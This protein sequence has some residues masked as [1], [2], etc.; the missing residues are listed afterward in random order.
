MPC[1]VL[2]ASGYGGDRGLGESDGASVAGAA[3]VFGFSG[4]AAVLRTLAVRAVGGI[5]SGWF[6]YYED[7]DLSWR[8]RLAGWQIVY[9]PA[10]VV[11]HRHAASSRTSR[12]E[13]F[14]FFNERNRLLTLVRNAPS[15]VTA[16]QLARFVVNDPVTGGE[17]G[18]Q[19]HGPTGSGVPS[20]PAPSGSRERRGDPA[21]RSRAPRSA[22]GTHPPEGLVRVGWGA[23]LARLPRR[24]LSG[25]VATVRIGIDATP[26]LGERTGV[27]TYTANLVRELVD[28]WSDQ[29]VETAFTWR[30][31]QG[32]SGVVPDRMEVAGLEPRLGC[33]GPPG[34]GSTGPP[35]RCS[36]V[37]STSSTRRTS[38]FPLRAAARR[39]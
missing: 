2:L 18:R 29:V 11:H 1:V 27:G 33:C 12:S 35:S 39:S 19:A 24:L 8:L 37:G 32:L 34:A 14:A 16:T 9:E 20:R 31:R 21:P 22:A 26:L 17:T 25:T 10:A 6:M 4:G 13:S 38:C 23:G 36:A 28:G 5:A 15:S 3:A 7:T 30:G